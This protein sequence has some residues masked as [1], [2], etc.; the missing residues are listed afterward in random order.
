MTRA[1]EL[2]AEGRV[3]FGTTERMDCQVDERE[4]RWLVVEADAVDEGAD[5]V[6]DEAAR[7]GGQR[8]EP[9]GDDAP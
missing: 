6:G 3:G 9:S 1:R 4:S 7:E 5:V 2:L 8:V